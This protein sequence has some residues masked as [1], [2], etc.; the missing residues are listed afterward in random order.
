MV[1]HGPDQAVSTLWPIVLRASS[2]KFS[3]ARIFC[4][5]NAW[6]TRSLIDTTWGSFK[7]ETM[8]LATSY[9]NEFQDLCFAAYH[10]PTHW[11][12]PEKKPDTFLHDT[13]AKTMVNVKWIFVKTI[14]R[15]V[16][17]N[18]PLSCPP[19]R[20]RSH[21]NDVMSC[22]WKLNE[23]QQIYFGMQLCLWPIAAI[24]K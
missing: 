20:P 1:A 14:F 12:F 3:F 24:T 17:C 23:R 4:P 7:G 18:Q 5:K 11:E 19:P 21:M 2:G 15:N 8:C 22:R 16:M 6:S 9:R 10:I 13:M